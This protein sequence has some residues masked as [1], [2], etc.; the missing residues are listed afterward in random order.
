[1][2]STPA[3]EAALDSVLDQL[4][5]ER[6][7]ARTVMSTS[8]DR[9]ARVVREQV[10]EGVLGAGTRLPESRLAAAIGVSRNTLREALSQLVAERILVREPHRGVVVA[11]PGPEDVADIYAV[12]RVVEPGAV[13]DGRARDPE[14]LRRVADAVVEGREA[15][16]RGDGAGVATANQHFHAAVVALAGSA[17]LDQQMELLLAEM[18]L[19][20]QRMGAPEDFHVPYLDRNAEI[21]D[22]IAADRRAEAATRLEDY[23]ADAERELLAGLDT[24]ARQPTR[25]HSTSQG[26]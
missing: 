18:R 14:R 26:G 17:R 22:L 7:R 9:A 19:V 4:E 20:F 5:A 15:R 25:G 10:V 16:D 6:R 1:M 13:R 3:S 21:A 2:A 12:R 11:T 8:G 23:L 24:S